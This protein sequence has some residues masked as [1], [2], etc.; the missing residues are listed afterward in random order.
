VI[1]KTGQFV[2][3]RLALHLEMKLDVLERERRLGSQR[4]QHLPVIVGERPAAPSYRDNAVGA[5]APSERTERERCH[6][7]RRS[8]AL[9]DSPVR[10]RGLLC[11]GNNVLEAGQRSLASGL[12]E[13]SSSLAGTL[14]RPP[15]P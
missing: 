14:I 15:P 6:A 5:L 8:V 7:H 2:R 11:L 13:R 3:D 10:Q 12:G 1:R 9:P 4:S